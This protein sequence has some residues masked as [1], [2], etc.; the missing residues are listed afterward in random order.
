MV[1]QCKQ[2]PFPLLDPP[3]AGIMVDDGILLYASL[4]AT[5][6]PASAPV[7][8]SFCEFRIDDRTLDALLLEPLPDDESPNEVDNDEAG[9]CVSVCADE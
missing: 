8:W 5:F 7:A 6:P 3:F 9:D 2:V 1:L 4:P